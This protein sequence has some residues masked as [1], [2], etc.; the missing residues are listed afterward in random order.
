[1]EVRVAL[2]LWMDSY[3]DVTEHG[4]GAGCRDDQKLAGVLAIG[5]ND[6]IANLP[7][8]SLVL[9]VND[10]EVANGGLAPWAPVDDI[11]AAIDQ[12]LYVEFVF[13]FVVGF[14]LLFVFG[15][16]FLFFVFVCV[17]LF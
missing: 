15:V 10:F 1:M 8:V 17:V 13:C 5:A 14:C 6:G 3:S 11:G 7:E 2:V 9:V 16:V 4:L 12:A